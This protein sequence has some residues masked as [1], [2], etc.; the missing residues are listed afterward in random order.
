MPQAHIDLEARKTTG[1]TV[2]NLNLV[3]NENF[4]KIAEIITDFRT[5]TTPLF[6]K[7][8]ID[9]LMYLKVIIAKN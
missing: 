2:L 6:L 4:S 9:L 3:I 8:I 1:S 5:I 7:K